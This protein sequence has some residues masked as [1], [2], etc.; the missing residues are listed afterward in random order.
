MF[1]ARRQCGTSTNHPS[2]L[3]RALLRRYDQV[4]EFD[5]PTSE[6][7]RKLVAANTRPMAILEPSWEKIVDAGNGLSQSE[8][9]RAADDAV[10]TAILD[11]RKELTTEDIVARL[12][13]RDADGIYGFGKFLMHAFPLQSSAH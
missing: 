5:T 8:I 10:K 9:V 12:Q 13:E 7:I 1:V 11:Q 6:Q 4:L 3:D 2:L